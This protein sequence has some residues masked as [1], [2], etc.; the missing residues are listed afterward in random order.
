M[1][2]AGGWRA[3]GSG[4]GYGLCL[5]EDFICDPRTDPHEALALL[6][7]FMSLVDDSEGIPDLLAECYRNRDSLKQ[8]VDLLR[9]A[10]AQAGW[11]TPKASLR[12]V[13]NNSR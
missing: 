6:R 13:V 2:R 12:L 11:S 10:R 4:S 9:L 5:I 1:T 7:E 8:T 3:R